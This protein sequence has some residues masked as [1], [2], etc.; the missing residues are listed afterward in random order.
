MSRR[1]T[2]CWS[3]KLQG[4]FRRHAYHTSR[5]DDFRI[6]TPTGMYALL[7]PT[8]MHEF[9]TIA[10]HP[11]VQ[12]MFGRPLFGHEYRNEEKKSRLLVSAYPYSLPFAW[13]AAASN[14]AVLVYDADG[15]IAASVVSD[16]YDSCTRPE[17]FSL[18][19]TRCGIRGHDESQRGYTHHLCTEH[20][21]REAI[22]RK[23]MSPV[24]LA[25]RVNPYSDNFDPYE[26]HRH[27][28]QHDTIGPFVYADPV[29][30]ID[31]PLDIPQEKVGKLYSAGELYPERVEANE[32]KLHTRAKSS[33]HTRK[34][35]KICDSQCWLANNC[36]WRGKR[37]TSRSWARYCQEE[38][39]SKYIKPRESLCGPFTE[40]RVLGM[41]QR[42]W[43][44]TQHRSLEEVSFIA[45]NAGTVISPFGYKMV[46]RSMDSNLQNV[47]FTIPYVRQYVWFHRVFTFE[48]AC[49][50]LRLPCR[51]YDYEKNYIVETIDANRLSPAELALYMELCQ[52]RAVRITRRRSSRERYIDKLRRFDG[53]FEL[54]PQNYWSTAHVSSL[55]DAVRVFGLRETIHDIDITSEGEEVTAH[56][57]SNSDKLL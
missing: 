38:E 24:N 47:V 44:T 1:F 23:K 3:G 36:D 4:T 26:L 57:G 27:F 32:M 31:D 19:C 6:S 5:F 10:R 48:D 53:T 12:Q 7:F 28:L 20:C 2:F 9:P 14:S 8:T 13:T 29:H 22:R 35:H 56:R 11:L 39:A 30:M 46:L 34:A 51:N 42:I 16:L 15:E 33:A 52:H 21:M 37:G 49:E 25:R 55:Q 45:N 54:H 18:Y 41:Y 40:E 17:K 43:D 50:L